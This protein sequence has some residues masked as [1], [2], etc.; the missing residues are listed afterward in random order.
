VLQ[1]SASALLN[2]GPVWHLNPGRLLLLLLN[3]AVPA[4]QGRLAAGARV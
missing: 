1:G 4:K 3:P 2:P